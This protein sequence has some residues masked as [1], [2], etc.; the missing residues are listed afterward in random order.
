MAIGFA[1]GVCSLMGF[2]YGPLHNLI[3]FLLLGIGIDDMFVTMQCFNNLDGKEAV[4]ESKTK[5]DLTNILHIQKK[6]LHER[7]GLTLRHAGCAITV[8][9]LTDFLAFAIGGTTVSLVQDI[10]SL[11]DFFL[12]I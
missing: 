6:K 5:E 10:Q 3:P 8:T 1:Y 2:K 12:Q 7:I 9:S 4:S 11:T